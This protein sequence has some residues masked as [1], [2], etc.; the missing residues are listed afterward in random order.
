MNVKYCNRLAFLFALII[1]K[2]IQKMTG[3]FKSVILLFTCGW[4]IIMCFIFILYL[5]VYYLLRLNSWHRSLQ[6]RDSFTV[7]VCLRFVTNVSCTTA[8][9]AVQSVTVNCTI[10]LC[11]RKRDS[12]VTICSVLPLSYI[13]IPCWYRNSSERAVDRLK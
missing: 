10:W 11:Y 7:F 2:N 1:K 3:M 5:T 13:L 12:L 9:I 6:L 4:C 8:S